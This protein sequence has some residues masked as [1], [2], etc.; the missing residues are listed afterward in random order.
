MTAVVT[1][2]KDVSTRVVAEAQLAD[3]LDREQA[4]RKD[5]EQVNRLKDEF[6]AT[7][8]HELRTPLNAIVGWTHILRAGALDAERTRQAIETIARN[9]QAQ[10]QLISDILDVS[11]IV[12]GKLRLEPA[13]I[14]LGDVVRQA[15][16]TVRPAAEAKRI[17]VD[18]CSTRRPGP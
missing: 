14:D 16:D 10:A 17:R 5:A 1:I 7:L 3:L 9:A 6:L 2:V 15:F 13:A 4:A 18:C 8:S 11:R 12:A